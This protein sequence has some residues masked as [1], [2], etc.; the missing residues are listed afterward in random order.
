M[1]NIVLFAKYGRAA[2]KPVA[3]FGA[4][5]TNIMP[6][7]SAAMN[8]LYTECAATGSE[9]PDFTLLLVDDVG[10]E[11]VWPPVTTTMEVV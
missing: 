2:R 7:A 9:Y 4:N 6:L 11:S 8:R 10:A 3:S 1:S 5:D